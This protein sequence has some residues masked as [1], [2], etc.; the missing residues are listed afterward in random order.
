MS[1]TEIVAGIAAVAAIF[2][3]ML[4]FINGRRVQQLHLLINS[5]LARQ[6]ASEVRAALAEGKALGVAEER[7]RQKG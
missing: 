7:D 1:D 5:N 4:S 3:S 6:I 2:S